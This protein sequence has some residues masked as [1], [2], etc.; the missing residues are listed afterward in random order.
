MLMTLPADWSLSVVRTEAAEG[1]CLCMQGA[2]SAP[3][4]WLPARSAPR[5][6]AWKG[7]D[8]AVEQRTT[9]ALLLP[10]PCRPSTAVTAMP[11]SVSPQQG[12][13]CHD[14]EVRE[15]P[16]GCLAGDAAICGQ[17]GKNDTPA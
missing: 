7:A 5:P 6:A 13:L 11:G 15:P 9:L 14:H 8:A 4:S 10:L 16:A 2:A 12:H 17:S 1:E 3:F